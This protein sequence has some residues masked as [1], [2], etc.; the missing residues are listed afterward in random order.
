MEQDIIKDRIY[1][2]MNSIKSYLR[3]NIIWERKKLA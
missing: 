3:E 2:Y 1:T